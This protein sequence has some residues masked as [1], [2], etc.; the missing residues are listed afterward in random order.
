MVLLSDAVF[1]EAFKRGLR[2]VLKAF[3]RSSKEK[4]TI[5]IGCMP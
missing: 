5:G 2:R 4:A 3:K 1:L